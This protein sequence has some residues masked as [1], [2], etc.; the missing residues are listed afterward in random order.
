MY[1]FIGNILHTTLHNNTQPDQYVYLFY[2][3]SPFTGDIGSVRDGGDTF[4]VLLQHGVKLVSSP[5]AC[6]GA[7]AV[8][9][10]HGVKECIDTIILALRVK[11]Y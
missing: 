4:R 3:S 8:L 10:Q 1:L 7:A 9:L 5:D 6:T 11:Y 2:W